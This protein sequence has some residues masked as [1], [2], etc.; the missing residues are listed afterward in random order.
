LTNFFFYWK[1]ALDQEE[2]IRLP[3]S[4]PHYYLYGETNPVSELE[5]LHVETIAA[6]VK[7]HAWEIEPHR[8]DNL[9]QIV[10]IGEG[11]MAANIDT[12]EVR[13]ESPSVILI[14][15][16]VV[17]GFKVSP[18]AE[19]TVLTIASSFLHRVFD[20]AEREDFPLLFL[21]A[22]VL[23]TDSSDRLESD[24]VRYIARINQEFRQPELGR[25]QAASAYLNL[26]FISVSRRAVLDRDGRG[27]GPPHFELFEKF[28]RLVEQN[29]RG[30]WSIRDYV[31]E[32]GVTENRL[33]SVCRRT[34]DQ[35]PL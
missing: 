18:D 27:Y 2:I 3:D 9:F 14:P 21:R 13:L 22:T 12:Q 31:R 32:R 10:V 23:G 7:L 16:T 4:I 1:V 15:P 20:E 26:L 17:H 11:E 29:Y 6:R 28:L 33:A 19:G 5:F 8:H 30:H 35:G 24:I 34:A 25:V